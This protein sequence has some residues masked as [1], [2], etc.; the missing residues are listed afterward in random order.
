MHKI[1]RMQK[2]L[3]ARQRVTDYILW[4]VLFLDIILCAHVTE[5]LAKITEKDFLFA[6]NNINIEDASL[7]FLRL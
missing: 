1:I 4:T 6:V 3:V 7:Q 5:L 2:K